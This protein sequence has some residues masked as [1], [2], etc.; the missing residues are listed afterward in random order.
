MTRNDR[1]QSHPMRPR[2]QD[3]SGLLHPQDA[4]LQTIPRIPFVSFSAVHAGD[5]RRSH[6]ECQPIGKDARRPRRSTTKYQTRSAIRQSSAPWCA[7]WPI[8]SL[9][10]EGSDEAASP[11]TSSERPRPRQRAGRRCRDE[12][13]QGTAHPVQRADGACHSRRTQDA[14]A[15]GGRPRQ[16]ASGSC[17]APCAATGSLPTW[18]RSPKAYKLHTNRNFAV[19][20]VLKDKHPSPQAGRF[21]FLTPY[22]GNAGL[23]W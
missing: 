8:C 7:S 17:P 23:M 1:R 12:Q 21:N 20:A 13:H 14:D 2:G 19:S 4:A 10:I 3:L 15:A 18:L 16:P 6:V 5:L 9:R 22:A 11:P